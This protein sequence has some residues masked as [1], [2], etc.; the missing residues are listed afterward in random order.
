[1]RENIKCNKTF[2]KK[3]IRSL[4]EWFLNNYGGIRTIKLLDKLKALGFKQASI[5]GISLGIDDLKIPETK[6]ILF[7]NTEKDLNKIEIKAKNG[8]INSLNRLDKITET[9][10]RTNEL[11]K[12]EVIKNLRQTDLLNP[13]YMMTFS[14]ARGNISQIKQLIGMRGLMSDSQGEIINLPIKSNLKEGLKIPEYFISCYGARKGLVD[15]AIKT[16]NSGYLTRRLIYAAQSLIVKKNDCKSKYNKLLLSLK[17]DKKYYKI[18]QEKIL[19][20]VIARD[21]YDKRKNKVIAS[22]GQ[23]I[24][25]YT[26]KRI[27]IYKKIYIRSPLTCKL[28]TG[29]CQLCYGWNLANGRMVELGESIGILAA[30]SIGEPG[31]QLTMRTFH[32]GGVFAGEVAETII[33]PHSGNIK[34]NSFSK[35]REIE[36]KYREK[37]FF[38]LEEK[39]L[40][41]TDGKTQKSVIYIP[42]YSIIFSKNNEEVSNRQILAQLCDWQE[43]KGKKKKKE[44]R[45]IKEIKTKISGQVYFDTI[46]KKE[47]NGIIWIINGNILTNK[48]LY[49][50]R[51][52][53]NYIIKHIFLETK[54]E[55][56]KQIN[57]INN[58]SK[59]QRIQKNYLS[60]K[61]LKKLKEFN[62]DNKLKSKIYCVNKVTNRKKEFLTNK[63]LLTKSLKIR[64][65]L[66][67]IGEFV[68]KNKIIGRRFVNKYP[69]QVIEIKKDHLKVQKAN[70]TTISKN[71]QINIKNNSLTKKNKT[72]FYTHH[73]KQKTEDIVQGLPKI[74]ELLEAKK[75]S[76][77]RSISNNPHEKLKKLFTC[78]EKK[79]SNEIAVRKSIDRIQKL[80]VEKIQSVYKTQGVN[81]CDKH[82]EIIIKQMTSKVIILEAGDSNLI[83]GE[84]IEINKIEKINYKLETKVKYEP[85]IIGISKIS[86]SNQSFISE[87]SFQETTSVLTKSAIEGKIDWL[88]G[89]KE[90]LILG[91]LI[92]VGTGY[93]MQKTL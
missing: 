52:K 42:C 39:K 62:I 68:Y 48:I 8:R 93:K 89:L 1:M 20:R 67:K 24:C 44:L 66:P 79:Y 56:Y 58:D 27:S 28:N 60:H 74:E 53:K 12:D 91:N 84:T 14:G 29:I 71:C 30:Q 22:A 57:I 40:T 82:M 33:A 45:E 37:A 9:W 55:N 76:N 3:E 77:F 85:I 5:A 75:T 11:L 41:I 51:I 92:P 10:N 7:K 26:L 59:T 15:T 81:I 87:A 2:D 43:L 63:K 86:L 32:T 36:T 83:N 31:T 78:F 4:I 65:N 70:P 47:E 46:N 34:Y 13:V 88:C 61:E 80:L 6:K 18:L 23:D 19:G 25:Q 64:E 16:A 17:K 73:Q 21:I 35:G 72:I 90:N 54:N 69:L 50:N 49:K 38:T